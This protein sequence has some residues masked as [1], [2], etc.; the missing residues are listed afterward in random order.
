MAIMYGVWRYS[1]KINRI[2]GN[3]LT[4]FAKAHTN[5]STQKGTSSSPKAKDIPLVLP[6]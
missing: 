4:I 3:Q 5:K 6:F 1:T 2:K